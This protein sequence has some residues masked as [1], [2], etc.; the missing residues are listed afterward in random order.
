MK[1]VEFG[2]AECVDF[3]D[4]PSDLFARNRSGLS[5]VDLSVD[6]SPK[7]ARASSAAFAALGSSDLYQSA[8]RTSG[9]K[10]AGPTAL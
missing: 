3:A 5:A 4:S 8:K 10:R 9:G 2:S 1:S 6:D 7:I